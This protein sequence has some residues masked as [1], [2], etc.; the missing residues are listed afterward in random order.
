M[1]GAAA[2]SS[3]PSYPAGA[4]P[5]VAEIVIDEA[6][7]A[8]AAPGAEATRLQ[9]ALQPPADAL[10]ACDLCREDGAQPA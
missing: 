1:L 9:A 7:A 5:H 2:C 10:D 8:E 6:E 4:R 3:T